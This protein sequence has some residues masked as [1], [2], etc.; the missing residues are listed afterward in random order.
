MAKKGIVVVTV[1]YRLGIFGYFTHP[2]LEKETDTKSAGNYGEL[3]IVAALRWI[4]DNIAAFGGDPAAV[5]IGGQSAGSLNT[6]VMVASPLAKGLFRGTIAES[7]SGMER[8]NNMV[9]KLADSEA[10]NLKFAEA[11]GAKS[12]T[13]L[14]K[15]TPE[16]LTAATPGAPGRFSPVVDG[17]VLPT[18]MAEIF[19]QGKQN[20]VPMLTGVNKDDNGGATPHPTVTAAEFQKQSQQ[21]YGAF[22]DDFLKLYPAGNDDQAK[23][24]FNDAARDWQRTSLYVWAER[25]GATAKTKVFTYYWDHTLPGPDADQFGAFHTSEVPYAL[26]SLAMSDRPFTKDD[27]KIADTLS[28]YWVNFIK[29]GDP[30]GKGLPHWPSLKEIPGQTMEI[31]DKYGPIPVAGS[32]EKFQLFENW[33][34]K[35]M[36]APVKQ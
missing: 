17:Y 2:E 7:G 20:D 26:N 1:N 30:N 6:H 23:V 4:R 11:K 35:T 12:L 33:Y 22:V 5:T 31:G 10:A 13:D 21:K 3:D 36:P 28:S 14:R 32:T 27:F 15:M 34:G 29:T 18:T 9:G 8:M 25:R 19:A 16:Q 24:A